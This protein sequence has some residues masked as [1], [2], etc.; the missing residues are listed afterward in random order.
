M[1]PI[2]VEVMLRVVSALALFDADGRVLLQRRPDGREMSGFWEFPGGKVQEGE[3]PEEALV[4]EIG[5]ELGLSLVLSCLSPFSFVSY[6]RGGGHFL[7]LLYVCREWGGVPRGLE[8][9]E[10][11][12]VRLSEARDLRL[13]PANDSLLAA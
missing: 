7:I 9:Q 6:S 13:L 10:T 5:E 11:R 12:W 3:T 8:G 4:R 2:G 1:P